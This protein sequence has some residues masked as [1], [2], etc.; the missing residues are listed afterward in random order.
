MGECRRSEIMILPL[1]ILPCLR[2]WVMKRGRPLSDFG[3]STFFGQFFGFQAGSSTVSGADGEADSIQMVKEW[4]GE[5]A[6]D[7]ESVSEFHG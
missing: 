1:I 4:H 3:F 7:A 5:F 2:I 6:A